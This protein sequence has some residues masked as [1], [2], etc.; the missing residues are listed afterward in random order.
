MRS[1]STTSLTPALR[2][3]TIGAAAST[4]TLPANLI[5]NSETVIMAEVEYPYS[6]PFDYVMP[7]QTTFR[8]TY[9]LRPRQSAGV[10]KTSSPRRSSRSARGPP[11]RACRAR[12]MWS[13]KRTFDLA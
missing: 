13:G 5:A 9:Y 12:P 4:V 7:A 11:W 3:S 10:T 2:T 1:F 8:K 6:S